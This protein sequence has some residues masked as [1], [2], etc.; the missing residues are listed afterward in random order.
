MKR[1]LFVCTVCIAG[2]LTSCNVGLIPAKDLFGEAAKA[3]KLS[4]KKTWSGF[5]AEASTDFAGT[6]DASY[7]PSTG[8]VVLKGAIASTSS[9]VLDKY[10]AWIA[11]MGE[12]RLA[13][14]Q[15]N[16]EINKIQ[17]EKFRAA[18]DVAR[19]L[20]EAGIG[21]VGEMV[22]TIGGSTVDVTTPFGGLS[23]M[24]GVPAPPVVAAPAPTG[25]SM[26]TTTITDAPVPVVV[27]V[28]VP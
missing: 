28:P 13:E 1:L 15:A 14:I 10:P 5:S 22:K 20:G 21:V 25:A 11:S 2:C 3:P 27:P 19:A 9:S 7:H 4:V 23:G 26:T 12:I 6:I 24:I 16:I 17:A 18:A 8:D